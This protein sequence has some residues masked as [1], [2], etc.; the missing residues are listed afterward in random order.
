MP[1]KLQEGQAY[2]CQVYIPVL[3]IPKI[4][5][6]PEYTPVHA[7]RN[8]TLRVKVSAVPAVLIMHFLFGS[9]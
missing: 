9:W 3:A 1:Q 7:R 6:R 2:H 8:V 5:F 4:T